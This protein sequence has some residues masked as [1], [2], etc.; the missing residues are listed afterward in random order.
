MGPE[1]HILD[2][3]LRDGGYVNEWDFKPEQA[4]KITQSLVDSRIDIIECGFISAT[5]GKVGTTNFPKL[6][7][8]N[9]MLAHV[10][11]PKDEATPAPLFVAMIN[12]GEFPLKDL[13]SCPATTVG[14]IEGIRLVFTKAQWKDAVK[15]APHIIDKGYK[16]FVQPMLTVGYQDM[17]ILE[18]LKAFDPLDF[19]AMYIVD[20][21][22]SMTGEQFR[23][24]HSLFENNLKPSA[25]L[26]YHAHNNMQL[27]YSN[28][29]TFLDLAERRNI[30]IDSSVLGM[31]RG[32]GNLNSELLTDYMNKRLG[33]AYKVQPLLEVID[34]S[35]AAIKRE[36][37]WGYSI[38]QFLSASLNIHPNYAGYLTRKCNLTVNDMDSILRNIP[39]ECRTRY[40]EKVIQES[41]LKWRKQFYMEENLDVS[42]F[43]GLN[44]CV[45][46]S[47]PS[48]RIHQGRIRSYV[49]D[50]SAIVVALNHV[51]DFMD[52]DYVFVNNQ[53]RYDEFIEKIEKSKL[54]ATT[55]L[56]LKSSH[57]GCHLVDFP[58]LVEETE[59][60]S[61]D[62]SAVLFFALARRMGVG[63]V[64]VAGLDGFGDGQNYNYDELA[65]VWDEKEMFTRNDELARATAHFG[66]AINLT[67]V[68]PS[69]FEKEL[70]I[71][72]CGVIPAR[73]KSS[74]FEGKPLFPIAGVPMIKRTYDQ[75]A[76]STVLDK[77]IVATDDDRIAKFCQENGI[78][79]M[80]TSSDC[81]TGTDRVAEVARRTDYN[82]FVNIQGDEPI[83]DPRTVDEVIEAYR[84]HRDEYIA[85]NL[86]KKVDSDDTPES[87][88]VI[89]VIV[90]EKNELMYM[91]RHPVPYEK[92][93]NERGFLKQVTVYGF[94]R[95][96][97]ELFSSTGKSQVEKSEDIEILRFLEKG[98]KV[99]MVE[100]ELDSIA[101]DIPDD[102]KRVEAWL[103]TNELK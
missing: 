18:M 26:G 11:F 64:G 10:Q 44:V 62:N 20:S 49:T 8:I 54:I 31:G 82:F 41:Y 102:V 16:L 77:L 91:S 7:M 85:Y 94:T 50:H 39:V 27:A 33:K 74:R 98:H 17:E 53:R 42:A 32:A 68:T 12:L 29:I 46:A 34:S 67:F 90:N 93:V 65:G 87:N 73:Y 5:T 47:G 95:R 84:K 96:S 78:P 79:F 97:L 75:V 100:T 21:F 66:T 59:P 60:V 30:I 103:E 69:R 71:R 57:I 25:R 13:P 14:K 55:N 99:M 61:S 9:E 19:Y 63:S 81:L 38:A 86:Y 58:R 4:L 1:R 101:V 48:A 43:K 3:T 15:V 83:I 88:T 80:M 6:D 92:G 35:L 51:P 2:C 36:K 22:G 45:V 56:H 72:A 70:P 28:S 89:K 37:P 23:R 76:K 52:H 24:Y 40:N